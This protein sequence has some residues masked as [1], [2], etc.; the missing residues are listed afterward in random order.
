[1]RVVAA[2]RE[3]VDRLRERA[4]AVPSSLT[5]AETVERA[6]SSVGPAVVEPLADLAPIVTAAVFA[7]QEPDEPTARRAWALEAQV[8]RSIDA[9]TPLVTRTRAA[10]DPRPLLPRQ[11]VRGPRS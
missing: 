10:V 9:G 7:P 5:A 8:R 4:V 11:R 1:V 6:R 2:W 3:T